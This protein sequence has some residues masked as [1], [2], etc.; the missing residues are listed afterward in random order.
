MAKAS[1]KKKQYESFRIK[2]LQFSFTESMSIIQGKKKGEHGKTPKGLR[3]YYG[4]LG[5]KNIQF[6]PS[7]HENITKS[8]K[9]TGVCCI[10]Y[11]SEYIQ[12]SNIWIAGLDFYE[13]NYLIKKNYKHQKK[14]A[15]QIKMVE[16]FV[17]IVK[18]HPHITYHLVSHYKNLSIENLKLL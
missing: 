17:K 16:S 4:H 6:L 11:V 8:I 3:K 12:P 7:E 10:S 18:R 2:S 14:K 15:K 1:L 9:N 5:L 13:S